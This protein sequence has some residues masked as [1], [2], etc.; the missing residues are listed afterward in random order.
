MIA[1]A[2]PEQYARAIEAVGNDPNVDALV[3]IYIPPFVT[4]PEEIARSIA[5][6]AGEV[7]RSKPVATVFM[8]SKG[9][10]PSLSS[11]P[12]G[13]L[14]SFA[15]PENAA[16][17]LAAAARYGRWRKRPRGAIVALAPEREREI[18]R[19]LDEASGSADARWVSP[20][21]VARILALA[22]IPFASLEEVAPNGDAA[23]EAAARIGYPVAMKAVSR[24]LLHKSD[25]GGVL[26]GIDSDDAARRA[27][28]TLTERLRAAGHELEAVIVQRQVAEGTE[29]L[30]GMTTD[31]SLGPLL[32]AGLGG[33]QVE[34][35]HD[36]AFR[37]TP[38]SDLDAAQMLEGLRLAKLLDGF[39]GAPPADREALA[40]LIQ[41]VSALV[42]CA[43]QL[44]ELELNPV[45]VLAPGRGVV[46]VDARMRLVG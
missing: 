20:R 44:A 4:Q 22:D 10:P 23:A 2:T 41:R 27:V 32:V 33:I 15:Y 18:R 36:V 6:G 31:P 19:I 39:R 8:S 13:N 42:E 26:L 46:A 3:A 5:K 24:G 16:M 29:A 25:V 28:D 17:A 12:R 40:A 7:P 38:V 34:L 9:I 21:D 14:P 1:S 35:L 11:G 30:V 45:K 37:I 43:P